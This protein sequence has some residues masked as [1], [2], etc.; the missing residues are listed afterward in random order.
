VG[1][2]GEIEGIY[3]QRRLMGKRGKLE[4]CKG[5]GR[6]IREGIQKRGKKNGRRI[7]RNA[8]EIHGKNA[9]WMG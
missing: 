8:R 2:L 1:I 9:I 5:S 6:G 7:E 4:E 3:S